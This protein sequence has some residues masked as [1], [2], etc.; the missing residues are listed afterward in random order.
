MTV[1]AGHLCYPLVVDDSGCLFG[2]QQ[3]QGCC[4]PIRCEI[5]SLQEQGLDV[6]LRVST[7]NKDVIEKLSPV[8]TGKLSNSS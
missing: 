8:I 7:E 1:I 3:G 2:P 5:L 6:Q 4:L